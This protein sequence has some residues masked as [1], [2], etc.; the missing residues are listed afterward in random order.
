MSELLYL[1][2]SRG[3]PENAKELIQAWS[4]TKDADANTGLLFLLDGDDPRLEEYLAID[5]PNWA[6]MEV[7]QRQPVAVLVNKAAVARAKGNFAIGFMGDD[8][9][10]RTPRWDAV[11]LE[12]L[13]EHGPSVIY[14]NDLFQKEKLPTSVVISS[15]IIRAL[16]WYSPPG[17]IHMYMDNAWLALGDGLQRLLYLPTVIVEHLHPVAGK[18]E[19]DQGYRDVNNEAVY[20][21][22]RAV[23]AQ[24]LQ[25]GYMA[26]LARVKAAIEG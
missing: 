1:V 20:A 3:R 5:L 9:R 19:W 21:H 17:L 26:D 6:A 22:D 25:E 15:S 7:G 18:A 24:W 14:T 8:H 2:P 13:L 11:I 23:L 4:E 10:P 12:A 16:G